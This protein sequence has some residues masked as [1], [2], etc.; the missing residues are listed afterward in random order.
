MIDSLLTLKCKLVKVGLTE[1]YTN[2]A[3]SA[4]LTTSDMDLLDIIYQTLY[5][6]NEKTQMLASTPTAFW[7]ILVNSFFEKSS[8][9]IYHTLFYRI[10]CLTLAI[11]YEPTLIVL[12]RKQSLITRLIDEYQDK[13]RITGKSAGD[14]LFKQEEDA[15]RF[16]S[17]SKETRGFIL[18]ILNQLRLMADARHSDLISRIISVHPRYQE[19]L[20]TLRKDT[21]AQ[22]EPIYAWKLE[23]CPRPPAHLGPTPPIQA[24]HFSPY[25]GT[26]PLMSNANDN[27]DASGIDL[28]SDFA[29][30]LGF[31]ET[32]K[33]TETP[34]EYLSRRN[35]DYSSSQS[36][37]EGFPMDIIWGE[38][39]TANDEDDSDGSS[40]SKSN[41]KKR[42]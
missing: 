37:N 5:N 41:K 11:N 39:L 34:Y 33:G 22:T 3:R 19:F 14:G 2:T 1:S 7:K 6:A 40:K 21:L 4:P 27:D 13:K 25:S 8:S 42:R 18:L 23:A 15:D 28:G 12:V 10:V 32:E 9:N 29:F 17:L 38:S 30:C 16:L 26:L 31:K 36:T 35:S 20:P 24:V